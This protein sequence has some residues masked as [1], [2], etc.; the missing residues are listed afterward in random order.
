VSTHFRA[1]I[2]TKK[3]NADIKCQSLDGKLAVGTYTARKRKFAESRK[4]RENKK[5]GNVVVVIERGRG[6]W[7]SMSSAGRVTE[8]GCCGSS[9]ASRGGDWQRGVGEQGTRL[10]NI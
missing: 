10:C 7:S 4:T 9:L 1:P 5:D 6:E 8:T 3:G 2:K